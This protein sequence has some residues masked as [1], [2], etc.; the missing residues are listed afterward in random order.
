MRSDIDRLMAARGMGAIIAAGGE[1]P[2]SIRAYL[3]NGLDIHGGITV[4]K[5]GEAPVM[6]VSA[7]EI[8]EAAASG[9]RV[10]TLDDLGWDKIYMAAEGDV[11]KAR[12]NLWGKIF[13]YFDLPPGKIGI[14]GTGD[15]SLWVELA[16]L[17]SEALPQYQLVGELNTTLFDEAFL[18]KDADEIKVIRE[19]AAKTN[20]VMQSTWNFISSH[21]AE[22]DTV[23]KADGTPLTIGDV[24]R[25]MRREM[26]DRELEC[27]DVI[28]AQ[29]RDAGFPHSRGTS[30]MALKLGQPIVFDLFPNQVG[31][32]YHHD[33]TRTWCIGHAPDKVQKIYDEVMQAFTTAVDTYAEPGQPCHTM[34]EAVLDYFEAQGHPTRRSQPGSAIGYSHSLGHGVGL[35]IHERPSLS[36]MVKEDI[37]Q[38]GN[39]ITIEPGLYYPDEGIG[40]RVEDSFIIDDDGQ[41]VSITPFHKELVLPLKG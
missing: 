3:S 20:E 26:L 30:S 39:F 31:G 32:G 25:H 24:K 16:R 13:E 9:L 21:R 8:E 10:V 36:H 7:M 33:C 22:G 18:T 2:N 41:L 17:L 34:Q 4:K 40:V 5:H 23:V 28:F 12:V 11:K 38:K 15:I 14:Y 35:N 37:F 29:G 27:P 1:F 6:I 19:V